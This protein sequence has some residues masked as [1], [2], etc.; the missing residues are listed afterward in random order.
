MATQKLKLK[1]ASAV[2]GIT[3]KDLQNLVQFGV[4]RPKKRNAIFWFDTNQLLLAKIAFHIKASLRTSFEY[5]AQLTKELSRVDLERF[6]RESLVLSSSPGQGKT[7]IEI[8]VPFRELKK[9]L[10]D[11]LPVADIY[12]DR[13]RGRK[14]KN[15]ESE[16]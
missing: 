2:L 14:R 3:Q 4:L 16:M 5:L 8:K 9:E 12:Q 15:W 13:P 10:Q 6:T 1:Q 7:P 11:A